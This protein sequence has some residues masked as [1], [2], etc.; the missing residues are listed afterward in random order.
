MA[1]LTEEEFSKHI[2]TE[3]RADFGEHKINLK[4]TEVKSYMRG[5]SLERN[6]ERFSLFFSGPPDLTFSQQSVHLQHESM[7]GIEIFLVPISSDA[8]GFC[9]EAIFNYFK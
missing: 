6:M 5:E 2:G 3:F 1:N 9:Y 7:G 8:N 4:L